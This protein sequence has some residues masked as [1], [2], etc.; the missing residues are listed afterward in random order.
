MYN[1]EPIK[2]VQYRLKVLIQMAANS[3]FPLEIH[4]PFKVFDIELKSAVNFVDP[5][6][7]AITWSITP[8]FLA[9]SAVKYVSL[10]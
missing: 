4:F 5:S 9:S 3:T 8:K 2:G 1:R 10:S 6:L 7:V